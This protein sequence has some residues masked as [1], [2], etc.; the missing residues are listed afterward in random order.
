MNKLIVGDGVSEVND[1]LLSDDDVDRHKVVSGSSG[2]TEDE[3]E[4]GGEVAV[5][6]LFSAPH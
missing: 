5:A 4:E 6:G 2:V 1:K 3:E